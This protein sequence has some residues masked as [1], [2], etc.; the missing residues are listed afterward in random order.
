MMTAQLELSFERNGACGAL[1]RREQRL[2]R[3]Q[4]WFDRMRQAVDR[5]FDWETAPG[6]PEQ[7]WFPGARRQPLGDRDADQMRW[8]STLPGEGAL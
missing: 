6:R 1:R 8:S 4:W 5:A 7:T 3:A 2:L